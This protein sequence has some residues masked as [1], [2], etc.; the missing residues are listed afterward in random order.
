MVSTA[1]LWR[2]GSRVWEIVHD[3]QKSP[4]DLQALGDLPPVFGPIRDRAALESRDDE[5]VDHWFDVPV[6]VAKSVAAFRYDEDPPGGGLDPFEVL[7][8]AQ[9]AGRKRWWPFGS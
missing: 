2:D 4:D 7:V 5:E 9:G 3:A 6:E 1:A 8:A